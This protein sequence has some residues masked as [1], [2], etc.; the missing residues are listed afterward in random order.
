MRDKCINSLE[1]N[2]IFKQGFVKIDLHKWE[3][4]KGCNTTSQILFEIFMLSRQGYSPTKDKI[5]LKFGHY[6]RIRNNNYET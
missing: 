5:W 4:E 3:W 1:T 6:L 2:Q